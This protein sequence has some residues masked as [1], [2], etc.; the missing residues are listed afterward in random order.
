MLDALFYLLFI[1]FISGHY[2]L[3]VSMFEKIKD[4]EE[5]TLSSSQQKSKASDHLPYWTYV[6]SFSSIHKSHALIGYLSLHT[7]GLSFYS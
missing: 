4:Y 3:D 1:L 6:L 5:K 7:L 2:R